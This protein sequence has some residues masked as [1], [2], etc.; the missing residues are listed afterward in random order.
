MH[1]LQI[2]P[3]PDPI[4]TDKATVVADSVVVKTDSVAADSTGYIVRVGEMAPDFTITLTDGKQI[5]LSA[6]RGKVF[7]SLK[8]FP[9]FAHAKQK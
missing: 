4:P 1:I 8:V 5:E 3:L 6:L 9:T 2:Y 7:A